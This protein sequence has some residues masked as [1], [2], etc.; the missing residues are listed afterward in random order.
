MTSSA[1]PADDVTTSAATVG[2]D[3]RKKLGQELAEAGDWR[4]AASIDRGNYNG[5]MQRKIFTVIE[6]T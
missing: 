2:G 4:E 1:L 6:R 3:R 5:K